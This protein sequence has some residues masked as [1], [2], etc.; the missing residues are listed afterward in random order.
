[1]EYGHLCCTIHNCAKSSGSLVVTHFYR[2]VALGHL[3]IEI[4]WVFPTLRTLVLTCPIVVKE[5]SVSAKFL[6]CF[7]EYVR[8]LTKGIVCRGMCP[9]VLN[10]S[11][12]CEHVSVVHGMVV[13]WLGRPRRFWWG[14]GR[15]L[16]G[17]G[18]QLVERLC[19]E[20]RYQMRAS[21]Q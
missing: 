14:G 17:S 11:G 2:V 7:K 18:P 9:V 12:V 19:I 20:Q 15:P 1:M 16:L 5:K 4:K 6:S 8:H 10:L 13:N 3:D 21:N